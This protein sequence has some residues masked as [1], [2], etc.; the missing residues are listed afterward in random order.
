MGVDRGDT[1]IRERVIFK[2]LSVVDSGLPRLAPDEAKLRAWFQKNQARYDQPARF[3]FQEAVLSGDSSEAAVRAFVD[4]LNDGE[5]GDTGAGLRV[6]RDRPHDTIVQGYGE[7]FAAALEAATPGS[8]QAM[9][10]RDGWRAVRLDA[11][12]AA[13]PAEFAD[14][15]GVVSQDWL[16]STA[17]ENRTRAVRAL[18]QK[19][20]IRRVAP[21]P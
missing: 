1:A 17:A 12:R 9:R 21:T 16:D 11:M 13:K 6:F 15:A 8:W 10:S 20:Q 14:Y 19:Y 3:T 7:P 5:G 18:A 2:A 4:R